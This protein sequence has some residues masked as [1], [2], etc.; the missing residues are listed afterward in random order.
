M[1]KLL[2]CTALELKLQMD[3]TANT[4]TVCN[5]KLYLEELQAGKPIQY[6]LNEAYFYDHMFFV[7]EHVLIPRQE[8]EELVHLIIQKISHLPQCS[9]LDI[10]TGSG[11]IPISIAKKCPN[12]EVS[13]MDISKEAIDVATSNAKTLNAN[14]QFF[15]D[16]ILHPQNKYPKYNVI[17]SNP[18]YICEEEKKLMHANVLEH[19]PELALFVPNESPLLF[20]DAITQFATTHL[21]ENGMLFFEINERFAEQTAQLLRDAQFSS[22]EIVTDINGKNRIVWGVK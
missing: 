13:S 20:Y 14:I 17:V 6:V 22:A 11:C 4:D 12:A 2:D 1:E 9:V 18:P 10:G 15:N 7:N 19:E 3:N 8:T 21:K 16:S 5:A